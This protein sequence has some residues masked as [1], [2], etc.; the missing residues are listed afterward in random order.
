M[1]WHWTLQRWYVH[2]RAASDPDGTLSPTPWWRVQ[3]ESQ[4]SRSA[5]LA[6]E[7]QQAT[8]LHEDGHVEDAAKHYKRAVKVSRLCQRNPPGIGDL[9]LPGVF[10]AWPSR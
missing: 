5:S 6:S 1:R 4:Q 10:R 2:A 7:Y 3:I 8:K 9:T